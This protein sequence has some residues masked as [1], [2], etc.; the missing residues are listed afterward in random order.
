M[1]KLYE[2]KD[3]LCDQLEAYSDKELNNS[4]LEAVDKLAHA[5]KNIDKV[6]EKCEE[7]DFGNSYGYSYYRPSYGR[8]NDGMINR[9]MSYARNGGGNM[10]NGG[11]YSRGYSMDNDII[12]S[13][14]ELMENTSDNGTRK[15]IQKFI[16]RLQNA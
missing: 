8:Y 11:S 16:Q 14:N 4:M 5:I 13:L 7:Q 9:G 6:I 3:K 10:N 15:E 12:Y 1:K 2:L